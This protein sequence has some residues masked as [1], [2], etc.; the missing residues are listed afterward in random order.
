MSLLQEKLLFDCYIQPEIKNDSPELFEELTSKLNSWKINFEIKHVLASEKEFILFCSPESYSL[1]YNELDNLVIIP[2]KGE[3][4]NNFR[5]KKKVFWF[6]G[7]S[8]W[9]SLF[10]YLNDYNSAVYKK[11][12]IDIKHKLDHSLELFEDSQNE[13]TLSFPSLDFQERKKYFDENVLRK[14]KPKNFSFFKDTDLFYENMNNWDFLVPLW[15]D[16]EFVAIKG[17]LSKKNASFLFGFLK[18]SWEE[19][20]N[21]QESKQISEEERLIEEVFKSSSLPM[22]IITKNA[23]LVIHNQSFVKLGLPPSQCLQYEHLAKVILHDTNVYKVTKISV[24]DDGKKFFFCFQNI[25]QAKRTSARSEELGIIS[26]SI[27]HELNNPLAGIMA[28][29]SLLA[30]DDNW[31]EDALKDLEE[32]RRGSSRCK[33]LVE[34]FLGFSRMNP[35]H[36]SKGTFEQALE[37]ALNLIRFRLVENNFK[38]SFQKDLSASQVLINNSI[39]SMVIYLILGELITSFSHHLLVSKNIDQQKLIEGKFYIEKKSQKEVFVMRIITNFDFEDALKNSKL[40]K[41]LLDLEAYDLQV[42]GRNVYLS[43]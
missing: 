32:M 16:N 20:Q 11:R 3:N 28:A 15:I 14:I 31:S 24:N 2:F 17:N 42:D 19:F 21:L 33:A 36:T 34:T 6:E 18:D 4:K 37:Q 22:A 35:Q 7:D 12:S 5:L 27:A 1:H 25:D 30:L 43:C 40:I 9:D 13:G 39:F 41:H 38:F 26:S 29:L 10:N 23:D 8:R